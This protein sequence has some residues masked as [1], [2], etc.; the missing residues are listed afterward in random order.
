M[1]KKVVLLSILLVLAL[2]FSLTACAP[3]DVPDEPDV[4]D[5]PD[6]PDEPEEK[7]LVI[8]YDMTVE[9][10]PAFYTLVEDHARI[11]QIY[12]A[13][14]QYGVDSLAL[15]PDLAE[16]WE[17]SEDGKTYTFFLRKG[18]KWHR[19]YGEFTAH[20]VE[21]SLNRIMDPAVNSPHT[22]TYSEAIE[23]V[24]VVDDYTVEVTFVDDNPNHIHLLSTYHGG[25]MVSKAAVEDLGEGFGENPVGTGP[26]MFKNWVK[27]D[28]LVLQAFPDYFEGKP[29]IDEVVFLEIPE[30]TVAELAL[31]RGE[32]DVLLK[33]QDGDLFKRF[34]DDPGFYTFAKGGQPVRGIQFDTRTPPL[35]DVR[36]R[37]AIAHLLDLELIVETIC[38]GLGTAAVSH[39][40][41]MFDEIPDVT[42]GLPSYP[43]DPEKAKKLFEEA[44][45]TNLGKAQI[46]AGGIWPDLFAHLQDQLRNIG[47]TLEIEQLETATWRDMRSQGQLSMTLFGT[48]TAPEPNRTLNLFLH[49]RSVPP[50]G[51]NIS[52]YDEVD[53]LIDAAR[54]ER[55]P[56][57][58]SQIYQEIQVK[59]MEDLPQL[60][61]YN[62]TFGQVVNNRVVGWNPGSFQ[63]NYRIDLVDVE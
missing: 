39:L 62:Y 19:D 6:V 15:E 35:S 55:D 25:Y 42:P 58:L 36:V 2:V 54:A 21:F 4:P 12:N 30:I 17:V 3:P 50:G 48:G 28:R 5:V 16:R 20:D 31:Q 9:L 1:R 11:H 63:A 13:L 26:Y 24:Q 60:P 51:L 37:R 29:P 22:P 43:Y 38:G 23:S 27:D 61:V 56:Q 41:P 33:V 59:L 49:S 47:V 14:I 32:I 8:R 34:I 46:T 53:D 45:V 18:V 10:D 44:G 57:K 40:S 52:F 7:Q